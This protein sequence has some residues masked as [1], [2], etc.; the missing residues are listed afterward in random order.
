MSRTA[1]PTVL[2]I[3]ED[4]VLFDY[5][6]DVLEA[7]GYRVLAAGSGREA[8]RA[9]AHARPHLIVA[10]ASLPDLDRFALMAGGREWAVPVIML[11][12]PTEAKPRRGVTA[13]PW[14]LDVGSLL[15]LVDRAVDQGV[16]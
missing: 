3:E 6:A 7:A 10:D 8:V 2:L 12:A 4:P 11:G 15:G 16:A 5:L 14:P 1:S 13:V 9:L